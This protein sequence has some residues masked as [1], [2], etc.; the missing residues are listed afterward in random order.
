MYSD[1]LVEWLLTMLTSKKTLNNKIYN[2]GSDEEIEIHDLANLFN[3]LCN[4][5]KKVYDPDNLITDRY[6]PNIDL[7]REVFNLN[8]KFNLMQSISSSL[9][10]LINKN[11]LN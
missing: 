9:D 7:T 8:L 11:Y 5:P 4:N 1:D 10:H 3:K 6:L 2:V